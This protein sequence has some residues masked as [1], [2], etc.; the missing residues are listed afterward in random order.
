MNLK[1]KYKS[2]ILKVKTHF[3]SVGGEE[4]FLVEFRLFGKLIY[5]YMQTYDATKVPANF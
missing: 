4:I 3:P 2:P 5:Q 1:K